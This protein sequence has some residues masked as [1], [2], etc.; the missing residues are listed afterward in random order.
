MSTALN[1]SGLNARYDRADIL[2]GLSLE[3]PAGQSVALLGRNGAGKTSLLHCLFNMG[4][5]WSGQITVHGQSI[6]GWPTHKIALLGMALVP[7]GRGRFPTLTVQES[8]RLAGLARRPRS[9][10]RWTLG[11]IYEA[12]PRLYERRQSSCSA[13]SGGERQL[14]ALARALLTQSSIIVLDEPSEG[15]APMTIQDT[16]LPQLQTLNEQGITVLIAEQ[17]LSLALQ[18]ADRALLLG[19]GQLVYDGPAEQLRQDAALLQRHLGL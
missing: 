15:L 18:L 16:L 13:L 17:N 7:Q 1:I 19:N 14:L 4:P 6:A 9:D 8:L 12:M 11:S 5:Q 10:D 3:I 2:E